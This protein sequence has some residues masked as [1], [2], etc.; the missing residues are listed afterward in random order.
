MEPNGIE[1]PALL[2]NRNATVMRNSWWLLSDIAELIGKNGNSV[3]K[4]LNKGLL[5]E[6]TDPE[7][8]SLIDDLDAAISRRS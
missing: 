6:G 7:F 3:T 1:S 5:K 2:G 8:K 4:W